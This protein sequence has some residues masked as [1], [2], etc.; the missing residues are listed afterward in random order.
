MRKKGSRLFEYHLPH[1]AQL[2]FTLI[3]TAVA[4]I[5][6]TI[7]LAATRR[8]TPNIPN[9][10]AQSSVNSPNKPSSIPSISPTSVLPQL[11]PLSPIASPQQK[12]IDVQDTSGLAYNVTT[13]P[14]LKLSE[15]LQKILNDLVNQATD[16]KLPTKP[17]SITL[18]DIRSG[19]YAQ[20]QQDELRFPAS[21]VKLF[22]M[23]I[24]YA[25][26]QGG[27]IP[28]GQVLTNDLYKMIQ[29]SDNESASRI[30]DEIT[31]TYS[32]PEK[33]NE[34]EFKTWQT[35]REQVNRF[36]QNAGY[37]N[38]NISQK[39]FPI[40]YLKLTEPKGTDLQIRGNPNKPTRN[41]ISTQQAARLMYEI[42]NQQAISPEYSQKM[43]Q[44]LTRDLRPEAWEHLDPN[45]GHFNPIRTFFGEL[46]PINNAYILSKAGWT[47]G[48]RQEVAFIRTRSGK[49]SYILAIFADDSAYAKDEKIFPQM[50]KLVFERMVERN[51]SR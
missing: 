30:L 6:V 51:S 47:S 17:L 34:K 38:I 36:F 3:A 46:L 43:K 9:S 35:Q 45:T 16:K 11:T 40:P 15:E 12:N 42:V 7:G 22:W 32:N 23:V 18:I 5:F 37:N 26:I 4:A 19:E 2:K 10:S 50:S 24:F 25:R 28:D 1:F 14:N 48:S 31:G 13:P 33:L 49:T 27:I 29:E 44:L 21:V 8:Q 39:T 20:Y 41:K